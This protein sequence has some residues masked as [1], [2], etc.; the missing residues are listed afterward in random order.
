MTTTVRIH[1]GGKYRAHVH[2]SHA[3][4]TQEEHVVDGTGVEG[5]SGEL[6]ISLRHP[7]DAIF[8]ISE[9]PIE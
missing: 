6:S 4:G 9:E 7:A 3:E 1:V 2:V 8:K 5:A